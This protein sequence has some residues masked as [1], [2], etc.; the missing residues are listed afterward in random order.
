MG[1]FGKKDVCPVCGK[2]IK[3]DVLLRIKD[4][5][6]IC[7]SCS[8]MVS[9]D[10]AMIPNQ[11]ADDIREHLKYRERNL[12]RFIRFEPTQEAKAGNFILYVDG[13]AGLWYCTKNKRDGNPPIFAFD[14]MSGMEYLEDGQPVE[15]EEKKGILGSLFGEKEE[16]KAIHSMKVRI[17]VDNPYTKTIDMEVIAPNSE[18]RTGTLSYKNSRRALERVMELLSEIQAGALK[19]NEDQPAEAS[20]FPDGAPELREGEPDPQS[21]AENIEE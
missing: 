11:T 14:E 6:E 13:P 15:E 9:M 17:L 18:L 5:V 16:P 4:N 2:R 8:S 21:D 7:A 20:D 19:P 1:L 12:D 3:G 10:A